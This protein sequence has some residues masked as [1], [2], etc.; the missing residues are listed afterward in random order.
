MS[1]TRPAAGGESCFA[2]FFLNLFC[3]L[4]SQCLGSSVANLGRSVVLDS[5]RIYEAGFLCPLCAMSLEEL[6]GSSVKLNQSLLNNRLIL[7]VSSLDVHHL[8]DG[9]T[10]CNPLI[11]RLGQVGNLGQV[12]VVAVLDQQRCNPESSSNR[13]RSWT[14]MRIF[15]HIPGNDAG[16]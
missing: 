13:N 9:H 5:A 2:G 7:A 8:G 10:A 11:C 12:S 14:G 6:E 16:R 4:K 1:L 3:L 15:L